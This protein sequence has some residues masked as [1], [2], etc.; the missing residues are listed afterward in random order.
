MECDTG[1]CPDRNQGEWDALQILTIILGVLIALLLLGLLIWLIVSV[2]NGDAANNGGGGSDSR[3]SSDSKSNT[4]ESWSSSSDTSSDRSRTSDSSKTPD[5]SK[6]PDSSKTSNTPDTHSS[7]SDFPSNPWGERD[8]RFRDRSSV[9]DVSPEPERLRKRNEPDSFDV[10]QGSMDLDDL[11]ETSGDSG[12]EPNTPPQSSA[13]PVQTPIHIIKTVPAVKPIPPVA[14]LRS[15]PIR[16]VPRPIPTAQIQQPTR[17][18]PI[19]PIIKS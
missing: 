2:I 12:S 10:A 9:A 5:T 3:S 18:V 8:G 1:V 15:E 6:T 13:K 14:Q 19:R 17:I 7:H 16:N 11:S 4:G